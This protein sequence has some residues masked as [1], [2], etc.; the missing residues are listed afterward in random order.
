MNAVI[1]INVIGQFVNANPSHRYTF[2][3]TLSDWQK[4]L[5][6]RQYKF[7]T[8]HTGLSRRHVRVGREFN[9]IVAVSTVQTQVIRV[10]FMAKSYWLFGLIP[11]I[12]IPGREI[13]PDK[14]YNS[15]RPERHARD[16]IGGNLICPFG[17]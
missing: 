5:A 15:K 2:A 7:M 17:K 6:I 13:I 11:H 4:L 16:Q 10:K 12:S 14:S 8:I 9:E 1:E 3:P